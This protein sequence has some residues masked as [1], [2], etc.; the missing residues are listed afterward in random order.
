MLIFRRIYAPVVA[1]LFHSPLQQLK[2]LL[3]TWLHLFQK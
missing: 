3:A 1:V 2:Q